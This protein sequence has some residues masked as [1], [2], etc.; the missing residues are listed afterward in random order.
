[1][2]PGYRM[3]PFAVQAQ[4]LTAGPALPPQSNMPLS[5]PRWSRPRCRRARLYCGGAS[6]AEVGVVRA[7]NFYLSGRRKN[8]YLPLERPSHPLGGYASTSRPQHSSESSREQWRRSSTRQACS[9]R[10]RS[11]KR[12]SAQSAD[13]NS[14]GSSQK[15][16][17][18]FLQCGGIVVQHLLDRDAQPLKDDRPGQARWLERK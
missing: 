10:G 11:L 1:M 13:P 18:Q 14:Q 17:S 16:R 7:P 5:P 9:S 8:R 12:G 3:T 2:T 4:V 15:N 6:Q